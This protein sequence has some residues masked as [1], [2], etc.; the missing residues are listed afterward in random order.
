MIHQIGASWE[1]KRAQIDFSASVELY[2]VDW[3]ILNDMSLRGRSVEDYREIHLVTER[4]RDADSWHCF[5]NPG[6]LPLISEEAIHVIGPQ[7]LRLFHLLPATV[8]GVPFAIPWPREPLDCFDR[9]NSEFE[10]FPS[11]GNIMLMNKIAFKTE[12]IDDPLLFTI[13]EYRELY[14]TQ[15]IK[16]TI[17]RAKLRGFRFEIVFG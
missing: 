7:P 17:V 9:A 2:G 1:R 14:C 10:V 16:D 8:D 3:E 4:R 6:T 12:R 11:S 15:S 5:M 13:P